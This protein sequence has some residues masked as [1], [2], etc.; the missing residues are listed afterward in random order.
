MKIQCPC[1]AKY[2]YDV[3]PENAVTPVKFICPACGLDSSDAVNELIRREFATRSSAPVVT[4]VVAPPPVPAAKVSGLRIHRDEAPVATAPPPVPTGAASAPPTVVLCAKHHEPAAEKCAVCHKPI[5]PKCMELFGYFCSPFCKN[6]AEANSLNVPVYAGQFAN[7]NA[8]FWRK[9]GLIMTVIGAVIVLALGTAIWYNFYAALPH[10]VFSVHFDQRAEAGQS[11]HVGTDQLVFL[12]GGTFSRYD[13]TTKKE[14]WSHELVTQKDVDD[15]VAQMTAAESRDTWRSG[16]DTK[17]REARETLEEQYSLLGT[18]KNLW[19][20]SSGKMTHYDW[21]TGA[22]LQTVSL[23]QQPGEMVAGDGELLMMQETA[24]GG[25]FITHVNY[26][27]G[28]SRT[29]AF[30]DAGKMTLVTANGTDSGSGL[31]SANGDPNRPLDPNKV[32]AQAQNLTTP[33]RLALPAL[34]ANNLHQQQLMKEMQDDDGDKPKPRAPA[35]ALPAESF[36]LVPSPYG[37]VQYTVK[38]MEQHIT[39]REAMKGPPAHRVMDGNLTAGQ[40]TEA[41]NEVLNDQQRA[42]GGDKVT[43]DESMYQ[44]TVQRPDDPAIPDWTGSLIGPPVVYVQKTVNVIAAGKTVTVLDKSN[45]KLWDASLLYDVSA[46]HAGPGGEA[47]QFGEGPCVEHGDTLYVMDQAVLTAFDLATGE[48]RWRLPSVGLLGL[49]FD[50]QGHIYV[51]TTTANVDKIKYSKQIDVDESIDAV[52]MKVDAKTGKNLWT[53]KTGGFAAYVSGPFVY[54]LQSHDKIVDDMASDLTAS[55]QKPAF[56][57]I[58]RLNPKNGHYLWEHDD[59]RA[60]LSVSFDKNII[61]L[62]FHKEVQVLR[63]MTL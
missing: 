57:K 40:G 45:K 62:V 59:D 21:D 31:P 47:S 5:C 4:S 33:A 56:M 13:L 6:K 34:L 41:I 63:F 53:A 25:K 36:T 23:D 10:P 50:D 14:V 29:E 17:E 54:T 1:G 7:V 16:N 9:T 18:G 52:L 51:N 28:E 60:P 43:E 30:H 37:Y 46:S 22:E 55:L 19:L 12:H 48:A 32:A 2:S 58:I 42:N 38:L 20:A 26:S 35:P 3:T 49:F 24:A 44:I 11:M 8:R 61:Y 39:T 27:T 15:L